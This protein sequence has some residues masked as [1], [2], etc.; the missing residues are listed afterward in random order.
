MKTATITKRIIVVSLILFTLIYSCRKEEVSEPQPPALTPYEVVY[1]GW[2]PQ[3]PENGANPMTVEGVALGRRLYYDTLLSNNGQSCSSCH[4]QN[5][6]FSDSTVNSLPH[7]NLGWNFAFL[8]NGHVQG[9]LEDAMMFEVEQ[10]FQTDI[11][12]L[13]AS[14]FY[15]AEFK[16]VFRT[17]VITSREVAFALAQFVRSIV[18]FDSRFDRYMGFVEMLNM[19][20]LSGYS[21]FNSERGDCFHC[22]PVG[23]FTDNRFH[24]NG[25]DSVYNPQTWGVYG[26]TGDPSDMGKYKTPSLRNVALTAPYMHDGRFA[27]LEDVVMFYNT[28]VNIT[29]TV[30]PIMTKPNHV[31]GLNLSVQEM[32]DLVAFLRCLTDTSLAGN[33]AYS[34]P[35]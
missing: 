32:S 23:L 13:N 9:T 29:S 5:L 15:R 33:P 8:W 27:T 24:N 3:L 30:D 7:I 22:H 2:I 34:N 11:S 35:W 17:E 16:K 25:L 31:Y 18:T 28:G 12:R 21:I 4:N 19:Q 14:T 26:E 6:S 10:F 1:P 20:E